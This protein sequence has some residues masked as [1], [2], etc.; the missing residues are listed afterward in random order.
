MNFVDKSSPSTGQTQNDTATSEKLTEPSCHP[1]KFL[2][3]ASRV[4][5]SRQQAR[6]LALLAL[7]AA[8]GTSAPA[9]SKKQGHG[10]SS[11][12]TLQAEQSDGLMPFVGL[13]DSSDTKRFRSQFRRQMSERRTSGGECSLLPT[14]T[15]STYGTSGNGTP[16][17]GRTE[18]A[19]R[20]KPSLHTMARRGMLPTPTAGD[21]RAS[22]SRRK[23]GSK[24]HPGVSLTDVVVHKQ[25]LYTHAERTKGGHLAPRFVEWMMGLPQGWTE[26]D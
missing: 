11:S 8:C 22:G 13:W 6:A 23:P 14:P 25:D 19:H 26:I 16:G 24:A 18:F 1:Q 15:A 5:T 21:A 2:Q 10:G 17:D 3:P 9:S 20:G 7:E 12:K 4:K